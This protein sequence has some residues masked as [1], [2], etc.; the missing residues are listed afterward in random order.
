MRPIGGTR[1]QQQASHPRRK[2]PAPSRQGIV[3]PASP[4]IQQRPVGVFSRAFRRRMRRGGKPGLCRES[5]KMSAGSAYL[6]IACPQRPPARLRVTAT[7]A[8]ADPGCPWGRHDAGSAPSAALTP[9]CRSTSSA[10]ID[11][12]G[13]RARQ[14]C[15]SAALARDLRTTAGTTSRS[16]RGITRSSANVP[17]RWMTST[18][19]PSLSRTLTA[20]PFPPSKSPEPRRWPVATS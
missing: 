1:H 15:I 2:G 11:K 8:N 12:N 18:S 4:A 20:P 16:V 9:G 6:S 19:N 17:W 7:S 10:R 13:I 5:S 14:P 3:N